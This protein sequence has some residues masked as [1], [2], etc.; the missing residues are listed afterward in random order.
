MIYALCLIFL[1]VGY[2]AGKVLGCGDEVEFM[3]ELLLVSRP[4]TRQE[5]LDCGWTSKLLTVNEVQMLADDFNLG[6][7]WPGN[8]RS[9]IRFND[10]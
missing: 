3:Y 4:Q 9:D 2:V 10:P 7:Q 1:V 6:P 5:L 8:L